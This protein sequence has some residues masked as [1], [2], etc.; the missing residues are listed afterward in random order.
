MPKQAAA[1][2]QHLDLRMASQCYRNGGAVGD[3]RGAQGERQV[4]HHLQRRGAAVQDH[5]LAWLH[6]RCASAAQ[7]PFFVGGQSSAHLHITDGGRS[8]QRTTVH[9]L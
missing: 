9:A 8:G 2:H 6:Q 1:Q 7:G 5:H 3:H 4:L